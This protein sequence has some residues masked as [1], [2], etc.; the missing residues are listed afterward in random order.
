MTV[1]I[2]RWTEIGFIYSLKKYSLL[3]GYLQLK[4][5]TKENVKKQIT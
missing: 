5:N 4:K 2:D 3:R 1:V